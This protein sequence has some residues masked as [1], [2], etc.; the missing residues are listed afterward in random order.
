MADRLLDKYF[1]D[2]PQDLEPELWIEIAEVAIDRGDTNHGLT[3]LTKAVLSDPDN[4]RAF[5]RQ[6]NLAYQIGDDA[7]AK[8][9]LHQWV[10][11]HQ[12][13]TTTAR[14]YQEFLDTGRLPQ[15][16]TWENMARP[17]HAR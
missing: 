9:S 5:L 4:Q 7:M 14:L 6:I 11:T 13:D 12:G 17:G 15:E 16:L 3:F 1:E 8:S 10:R 2:R